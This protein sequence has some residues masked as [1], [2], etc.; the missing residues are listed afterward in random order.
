M[1]G[2]KITSGKMISVI[3][4]YLKDLGKKYPEIKIE[5][6]GE[7]EDTQE[8]M[9]SLMR[10]FMVAFVGIAALLIVTFRKLIQPVIILFTIPMGVI[11]VVYAL[12]LHG[13]PLSFMSMLGVVALSGVIVNNAIVLITFINQLRQE[14]GLNRYDSII[15][16]AKTRL[17]P[18]F[19]TTLTTVS[20]L[21]PTAYGLGGSDP[22]IKPLALSLGWGL[23][24]GSLFIAI[25]FPAIISLL[26]D[27]YYVLET[28]LV[29]RH[30]K[31]KE[32]LS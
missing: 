22:F 1:D 18:I 12:L 25:F 5:I 24:I 16:A 19:M 31:N 17:R 26:D 9:A 15:E 7:N 27:F 30:N 28:Y 13:K 6:G 3:Q 20:G 23:A 4:P 11:G 32:S 21:L 2:K 8:S 14:D 29:K 10:A